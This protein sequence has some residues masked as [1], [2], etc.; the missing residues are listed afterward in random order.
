MRY[1]NAALDTFLASTRKCI[2]SESIRKWTETEKNAPVI[3]DM[4]K[5]Y[6]TRLQKPACPDPLYFAT[7]LTCVAMGA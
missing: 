6:F 1:T 5:A 2:E 3:R 7:Y 4:A